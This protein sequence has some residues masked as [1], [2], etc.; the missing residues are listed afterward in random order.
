VQEAP[1][2]PVT[3]DLA[4]GRGSDLHMFGSNLDVQISDGVAL[5]NKLHV[6]GRR[7]N[8]YCLFNNFAPQTLSSFI[9]G[10][11]ASANSNPRSRASRPATSGTATLVSTGAAVNPNSYVASMGFWIVQKQIQSFSDDLRFHLRFVSRQQ[12]DGGR[13]PGGLFLQRSLVAG[14]QRTHHGRARMR[15]LI[16]LTLNN[17][18]NVTNPAGQLG[19]SFFTLVENWNGFNTALFASDQ[20]KLDQWLFDAGYRIEEQRITAPSRTT[21]R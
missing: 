17:G 14:Q 7:V 11:I 8:C 12:A 21:P 5:S 13:L 18:V 19:A 20:W 15:N 10:E 4:N 2:P 9:S 16:D 6:L 3:A 1:A